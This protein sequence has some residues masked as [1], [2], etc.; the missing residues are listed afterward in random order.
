MYG[1]KLL[2]LNTHSLTQED[3]Q[4]KLNL[5]VDEISTIS[6]D[7]IALQE[8]NQSIDAKVVNTNC[9]VCGDYKIKQDNHALTVVNMLCQKGIN[10]HWSYL[11]VKIG[12]DKYDE[13]LAIL[14]KTPIS[15]IRQISLCDTDDYTNWKNRKALL[16]K[17]EGVGFVCN[18]HFGWWDDESCCFKHQF[19]K[20]LNHLPNQKIWL[21]GDFNC[22]DTK[23]DEGYDYVVKN[24]WNDLYR[25]VS[26][27]S[28]YTVPGSID[29]W[30]GCAPKRIDYIF[31]NR[32]VPVK[33]CD[34]CFDK[35]RVSDHFGVVAHIDINIGKRSSG[36]L[37]PVFSLPSKY[38]I[39]CF[40][41]SAYD[42]VDF[43]HSCGQKYWQILPLG[44]TGFGNSPYQSFSSFAGNPYFISLDDLIECGLIDKDICN[45]TDFGDGNYVDY[46]KLYHNRLNILNYAYKKWKPTDNYYNF[47]SSNN[48]W[49]DDYALFAA[50]KDEFNGKPWYEWDKDIKTCECYAVEKYKQR[51]SDV[52]DFHKFVQYMFFKQWNNLKRYA[53]DK[54]ISIIG[55]IPIYASYDSCDCWINP[56]LFKLNKNLEP[57]FVAGCPP[58]GFSPLGQLWGNPVYNWQYHKDTNYLWWSMRVA[59]C[60]KMYDVVRIDHFRGFDE[61]YSIPYPAT[62]AKG[63]KWQKGPGYQLFDTFKKLGI[64]DDF[65]A[66]DLGFVT[67]GVKSLIKKCGYPGMKI[68]QFAFDT[69]DDS[70]NDHLPY[71]YTKNSVVYTGTH[72]NYTL[73]GWLKSIDDKTKN[74]VEQYVSSDDL[75]TGLIKCAMSSVCDICII[76]M[77]D[78]LE[79]DD[80]ARINVPS[81]SGNNWMWR[82]S[83]MEECCKV[84]QKIKNITKLYGR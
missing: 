40:D 74:Y 20:L 60:M 68:I 15:D 28:G 55:D 6:P 80:T 56:K 73:K 62:D 1:I 71:N 66:E 46:D 39:G 54:G 49:L 24:G 36:V 48:F 3:Y 83:S 30:K 11:P 34:V 21:M 37:L 75:V 47:C 5:F 79:L 26:D 13:G 51:L 27:D 42:F 18:V 22:P 77:Q 45:N 7:I 76:P 81:T 38:G 82:L 4:Q 78:Y 12:Y 17:A 52:I 58:D 32:Q 61:Y 33:K 44:V 31:C 63:G 65:I 41:K 50:L 67:D 16:V 72:D 57:A 25:M 69:R 43:L 53:N 59:F 19:D 10:Y 64:R 70:S 29:G 84:G 23:R 8:V 35:V 14:S 2:T 9:K